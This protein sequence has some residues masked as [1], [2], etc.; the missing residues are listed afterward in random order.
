[1]RSGNEILEH[2][3]NKLSLK[4][5]EGISNGDGQAIYHNC[6][7]LTILVNFLKRQ[8]DA[9]EIDQ[10]YDTKDEST[11]NYDETNFINNVKENI[12]TLCSKLKIDPSY[13]IK[14]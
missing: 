8:K 7:L 5:L 4:W 14:T 13:K 6:V 2:I 10:K 1:M 3:L 11:L 9:R 12:A